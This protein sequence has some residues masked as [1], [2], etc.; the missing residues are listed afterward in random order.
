MN[1]KLS[2]SKSQFMRG[3]QC[4]KSL[5]LYKYN[6][7]LRTPPDAMQ[8]AIFDMGT[9]VGLYARQLFPGG[10]AIE[11]EG[12]TFAEKVRKTQELVQGG[13]H[14]IYE[15]TISHNDIIV[16]VD[17]LHKG[18]KGW[19]LYEVKSSSRLKDEHAKDVSIQYYVLK[20]SGLTVSKA[21]LV[22]INNEYVRHGD[23]AIAEL[24]AVE[25]LTDEVQES[26]AFIGNELLTIRSMLQ[27]PCPDIDIGAHCTSPYDCD[28]ID[29]CWQH[30]PENSVFDLRG[31]GI[32]KFE[33]YTSDIIRFQDLHLG[34]LNLKQRMQVEAELND[35]ETIDYKGIAE[36]LDTLHYP[37]Y[38][39]DFETFMPAIPRFEGTRPYQNIPFQYS[40]HVLDHDGADLKHHE[41]LAEAGRDP[42]E[43][44]A[45]DLSTLI[46]DNA[47]VITYN[48]SFEKGRIKELAEQFPRYAEKLMQ[49]QDS[50][51]DLM[52]P[53]RQRLYYKKEM[54][55]SYSIKYVL[56]ALVPDLGYE[57]MVISG[58]SD[59][60]NVYAGLYLVED[61]KEVEK[62]R[63]DLRAYC[64][65]DTLGMVRILDKLREVSRNTP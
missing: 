47:C 54:K 15:A 7:E 4:R 46:P 36:F 58:G 8:Q 40:L 41:F 29:H 42:R 35:T 30:I 64:R 39:L 32:D 51:V 3:L 2:L 56:P 57:G 24:F 50:I 23:I 31:K 27:G 9:E 49:I 14:T 11:Y 18:R 17:I 45:R 21:A 22:H 5:W 44:I 1:S 16:M 12:S 43:R 52:V 13:E 33:Y 26:E 55:G 19:E 63:E 62:I 25:E 37:Q 20:G 38:F 6:P 61:T 48:S 59:A 65:M 60:M 10:T 34:T 28:F 53:F